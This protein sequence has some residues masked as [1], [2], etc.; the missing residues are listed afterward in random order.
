LRNGN[1]YHS[2]V[3]KT[4]GHEQTKN[5][6]TANSLKMIKFYEKCDRCCL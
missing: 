3:K 5:S 1:A 6:A 2:R 4:L